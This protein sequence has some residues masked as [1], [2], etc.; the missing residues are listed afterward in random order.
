[1]SRVDAIVL[2]SIRFGEADRIVH[3]LAAAGRIAA[4]AKG[5]RRTRSKLG[6]LLEPGSHV[7]LHLVRGRGELATVTGADL[8]DRHHGLVAD[9]ARYLVSQ[10]ALEAALRMSEDGGP[11]ERAFR[12]LSRYLDEVDAGGPLP[13]GPRAPR[14]AVWLAYLAKL[15]YVSGLMPELTRCAACGRTD[16][17]VAFSARAGGA[18]CD[19]C[20]PP[21]PTADVVDFGAEDAEVLRAMLGRPLAEIRGLVLAPRAAD[22]VGEALLAQLST[23]LGVR[24]RA[25]AIGGR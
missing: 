10:Q 12:L 5:S 18:L 3:A 20:A 9:V 11:S 1:M 15:L 25:V 22:R 2:R 16:R 14:Q 19:G 13:E 17:L 7:V 21:E 23:H 4:I 8:I 6:A 24:L